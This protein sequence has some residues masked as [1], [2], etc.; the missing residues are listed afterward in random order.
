MI[1]NKLTANALSVVLV[2]YR[3]LTILNLHN[4]KSL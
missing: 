3:L 2:S 1:L 4:Q